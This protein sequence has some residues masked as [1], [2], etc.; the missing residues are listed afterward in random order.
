MY[1]IK[2]L[3]GLYA[4]HSFAPD[5]QV[6]ECSSANPQSLFSVTRT[7][8]EVS[9]I[10]DSAITL[11]SICRE[12]DFKCMKIEALLDFALVGVLSRI[13]SILA[14]AKVSVFALSTFNTDYVL[15]KS[16]DLAMV[17]RCLGDAGYSISH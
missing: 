7:D 1:P 15:F 13:T 4:V 17:E 6:P 11:D 3:A 2:I 12:D 10:C 9:V 16:V 14:E 8:E 5:A